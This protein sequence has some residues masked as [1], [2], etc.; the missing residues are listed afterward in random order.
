[1][2]RPLQLCQK[3]SQRR[4]PVFGPPGLLDPII[5]YG[6]RGMV[7]TPCAPPVNANRA[8]D[9]SVKEFALTIG[10]GGFRCE[11]EL[12]E[13][14]RYGNSAVEKPIWANTIPTLILHQLGLQQTQLSLHHDD[15]CC[16]LT[17]GP[18]HGFR[19]VLS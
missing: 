9:P 14:V 15:R 11:N 10:P 4:T 16:R 12:T 17:D 5:D 19:E 13:T 8:G 6:A 7:R 3:V 18:K 1:M 2:K